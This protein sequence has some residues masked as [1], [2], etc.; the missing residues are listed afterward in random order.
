MKQPRLT[1]LRPRVASLGRL[2]GAD[3][4]GAAVYDSREWRQLIATL[5]RQRGRRCEDPAC[6]TPNRGAGGR[7]YGDHI[8][9]LTDG[10]ALLDP[11]N[12]MLRCAPCHGRKTADERAKRM[13][14][15]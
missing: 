6:K 5:I 1:M 12:I 4:K 11:Q 14:V 10:G 3:K 7:V 2:A 9:E 15:R 8:H 13:G